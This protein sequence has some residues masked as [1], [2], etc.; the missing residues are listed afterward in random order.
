MRIDKV[1]IGDFKNLKKFSIDFDETKMKT[2]LLGQNT[3]GK[4]NFIRKGI[5]TN[6]FIL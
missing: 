6:L 2:V 1:S 4:S 3:T 5:K